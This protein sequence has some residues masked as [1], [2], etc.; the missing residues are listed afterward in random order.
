MLLNALEIARSKS[1]LNVPGQEY[2]ALKEISSE[3]PEVAEVFYQSQ[4]ISLHILFILYH[5]L[6]FGF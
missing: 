3:L 4:I 1:V 2:V 6:P 5:S